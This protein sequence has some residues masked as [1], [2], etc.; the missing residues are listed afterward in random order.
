[1]LCRRRCQIPLR[2]ATFADE[3]GPK[4]HVP[5]GIASDADLGRRF[6]EFPTG[7]LVAARD[8]LQEHPV[9]FKLQQVVV[10]VKAAD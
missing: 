5:P 10:A 9:L 7:R 1:M 6:G 3:L 4:D 8:A 2:Y